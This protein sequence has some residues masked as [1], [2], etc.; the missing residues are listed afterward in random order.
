[1]MAWEVEADRELTDVRLYPKIYEDNNI[2]FN[3][4]GS[5]YTRVGFREYSGKPWRSMI[6]KSS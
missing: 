3:G 6:D 4:F 5:C 1:M 2:A